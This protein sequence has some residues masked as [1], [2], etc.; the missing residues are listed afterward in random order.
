MNNVELARKCL[1]MIRDIAE[2]GALSW[3]PNIVGWA[4]QELTQVLVERTGEQDRLFE[5]VTAGEIDDLPA[6]YEELTWVE[7]FSQDFTAHK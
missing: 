7:A 2:R 6:L 5:P 1:T 3:D 4:L